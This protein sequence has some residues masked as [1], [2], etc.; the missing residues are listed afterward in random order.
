MYKHGDIFQS[1][2]SSFTYRVIG[3]VCRLWDREE[4]LYPH[5]SLQWRGK[6]PSWNR[7]GK[8]FVADLATKRSPS[9]SVELIGGPSP[10]PM[11]VTL[12]W[13]PLSEADRE[14]WFSHPTPANLAEWRKKFLVA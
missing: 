7:Q 1:P 13:K 5:C 3:P 4:M 2:G 11:I 10:I 9:Y 14:W 8:R 6:S 12:Y